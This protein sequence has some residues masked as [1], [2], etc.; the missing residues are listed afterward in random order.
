MTS[1]N[2]FGAQNDYDYN[3][4]ANN[5]ADD[6]DS[7]VADDANS[8]T[9]GDADSWTNDD[10]SNWSADNQDLNGFE[11]SNGAAATYNAGSSTKWSKP[12]VSEKR[13]Y[14]K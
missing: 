9:A 4:D 13:M 10:A 11:Y 3:A 1:L 6:A 5:Y 2:S 12:V 14:R 8:W 7:W